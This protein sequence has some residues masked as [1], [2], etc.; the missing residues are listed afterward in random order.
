MGVIILLLSLQEY[1]EVQTDTK[2]KYGSVKTEDS[3]NVIEITRHNWLNP[4]KEYAAI[5]IKNIG[6]S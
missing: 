2:D 4:T 6:K 3:N 1:A 5:E